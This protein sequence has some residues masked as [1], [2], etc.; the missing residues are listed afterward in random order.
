MTMSPSNCS[1]HEKTNSE[2]DSHAFDDLSSF[3]T[4]TETTTD[5]EG[6]TSATLLRS[7]GS[8][9]GDNNYSNI[10]STPVQDGESFETE[11]EALIQDLSMAHVADLNSAVKLELGESD[12]YP[13]CFNHLDPNQA[14]VDGM[15]DNNGILAEN[16]CYYYC[17]TSGDGSTQSQFMGNGYTNSIVD[18]D[19]KSYEYDMEA[20]IAAASI[21]PASTADIMT[22]NPTSESKGYFDT[23]NIADFL[24]VGDNLLTPLRKSNWSSMNWNPGE[25]SVH[26]SNRS[27]SNMTGF[28]NRTSGTR[29]SRR[30]GHS[31]S[32]GRSSAGSVTEKRENAC[33][34]ERS[35]MK[36]MNRAFDAL[37]AKIPFRK[38]RGRKIS[39]IE[40]LRSAIKY[41]DHL[42]TYLR[43]VPPAAVVPPAADPS[44]EPH[45]LSLDMRNDNY[46]ESSNVRL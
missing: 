21:I 31:R 9:E 10:D 24:P 15:Y 34:R 32:S 3:N 5:D 43:N 16:G 35:R 41:I 17:S 36:Q 11:E 46:Y 39:K 42:Q 40:A 33:T 23:P 25:S 19:G 4:E 20:E 1:E 7:T 28:D 27:I 22:Q 6:R 18:P 45:S 37:R 2:D 12:N 30:G 44:S 29:G 13:F 38:P 26:N 14:Y 8:Q